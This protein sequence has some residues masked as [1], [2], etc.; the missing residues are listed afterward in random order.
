M[1]PARIDPNAPDAMDRALIAAHDEGS[2]LLAY[3]DA[4]GP[5]AAVVSMDAYR[6]LRRLQDHE[7]RALVGNRA[8]ALDAGDED[9]IVL[10]GPA[11]VRHF[12]NVL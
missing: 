4:E 1:E 12:L 9:A 3:P 5:V 2:G 7:D 6:D 8:A 11:Q 10:D